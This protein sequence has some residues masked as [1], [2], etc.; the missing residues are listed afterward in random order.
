MEGNLQTKVVISKF[1]ISEIPF[2]HRT[3]EPQ[4]RIWYVFLFATEDMHESEVL[5]G[6]KSLIEFILVSL[7]GIW[8]LVIFLAQQQPHFYIFFL[9]KLLNRLLGS[10]KTNTDSYLEPWSTN[11]YFPEESRA[12]GISSLVRPSD[13]NNFYARLII[14]TSL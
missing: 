6:N 14:L 12:F 2:L 13:E 9:N 1:E 7:K 4:L 3:R 11:A 8:C 10:R 5:F